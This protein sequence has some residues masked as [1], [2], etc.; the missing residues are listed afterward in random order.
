[1]MDQRAEALPLEDE[2][3]LPLRPASSKD[4]IAHAVKRAVDT[5]GRTSAPSSELDDHRTLR[6]R[7][8]TTTFI[9]PNILSE[10]YYRLRRSY[11]LF[12]GLLLSLTLIGLAS[13][14]QPFRSFDIT[15]LRPEL[16]PVAIVLL[17]FYFGSR[18]WL[19]WFQITS[20]LGHPT[21][22]FRIDYFVTHLLAFTAV[23]LWAI[24]QLGTLDVRYSLLVPQALIA[25][26]LIIWFMWTRMDDFFDRTIL[27]SFLLLLLFVG[28][29]LQAFD[30]V[31][32]SAVGQCIVGLLVGGLGYKLF[33]AVVG[34]EK[35]SVRKALDIWFKEDKWHYTYYGALHREQDSWLARLRERL[36]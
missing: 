5:R 30:D 12:A 11:A 3:R 20:S 22:A 1:M 23:G 18:Y 36:M 31:I 26:V 29:T 2:P 19:H 15:I 9:E 16:F 27:M 6:V 32:V 13:G 25:I 33:A 4:I 7:H 17:V 28:L 8:P 10:H 35:Y 21:M 14:S 24:R 34:L